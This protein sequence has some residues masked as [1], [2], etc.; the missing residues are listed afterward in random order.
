M[1]K[2]HKSMDTLG[3]NFTNFMLEDSGLE[4]QCSN[5]YLSKSFFL[6]YSIAKKPGGKYWFIDFSSLLLYIVIYKQI[7]KNS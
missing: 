7:F 1:L 4:T 5:K 2:Q 3:R 6:S